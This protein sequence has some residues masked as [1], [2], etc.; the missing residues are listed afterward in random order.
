MVFALT[1]LEGPILRVVRCV[2]LAPD[3][4]VYVLTEVSSVGAGWVTGFET[5]RTA[6]DEAG[7]YALGLLKITISRRRRTCA[8]Q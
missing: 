5:E 4:V 1:G 8:I 2:V 6:P 3:A 7:D